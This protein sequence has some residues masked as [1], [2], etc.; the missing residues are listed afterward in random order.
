[1][2][3]FILKTGLLLACLMLGLP[4]SPVRANDAIFPPAPAAAATINFDG[5]GFIVRGQRE[6]V[7][8]AAS[9]SPACRANFGATGCC[10]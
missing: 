9:I 5:N 1:M 2:K 3:R 6:F 7:A 4:P 8:S 10:N